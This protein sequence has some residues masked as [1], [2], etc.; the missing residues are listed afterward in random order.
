MLHLVSYQLDKTRW[1]PGE[2]LQLRLYWFAQQSPLEDYK[3]FLHL[4][5]LDDSG[6][7]AQMDTLPMFNFSSTTRWESGELKFDQLRLPLETGI[8]P[9]RYRLVLG[10]YPIDTV[11]NLSI[12]SGENVLPG[13]RLVLAEVEIVNE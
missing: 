1:H 6:K 13:D 4:T 8:K 11:Q 7:V 2:V 3:V 9:G 12:R 10:L 5:E